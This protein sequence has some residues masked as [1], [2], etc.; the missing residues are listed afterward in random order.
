MVEQRFSQF[1][2]RMES[3]PDADT[4]HLTI[5]QQCRENEAEQGSEY[6]TVCLIMFAMLKTRAWCDPF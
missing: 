1:Q 3:N 5:C 2:G 6:C 4:A